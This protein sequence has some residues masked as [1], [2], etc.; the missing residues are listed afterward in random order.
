[1]DRKA[2]GEVKGKAK[3]TGGDKEKDDDDTAAKLHLRALERECAKKSISDQDK[4]VRLLSLTHA[5]RQ[6]EMANLT[7]AVRP[8]ETLK[9]FS[10]LGMASYVGS[11]LI[12][13]VCITVDIRTKLPVT[14][15]HVTLFQ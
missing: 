7:A 11:E 1:M 5:A 3:A 9:R 13:V 15:V 12:L 14:K 2:C 10:I 6:E 8:T 4:V